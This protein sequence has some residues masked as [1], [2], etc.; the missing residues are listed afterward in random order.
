M[1]TQ[2]K[3]NSENIKPGW[4]PEIRVDIENDTALVKTPPS[5]TEENRDKIEPR[6]RMIIHNQG[7]PVILQ[8]GHERK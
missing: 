3:K 2:P 4:M 7:S 6:K 8:F 5:A 1:K